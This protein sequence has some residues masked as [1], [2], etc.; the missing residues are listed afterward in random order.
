[1]IKEI[2]IGNDAYLIDQKVKQLTRDFDVI[3][4]S[5]FT[6]TEILALRQQSIFGKN[7]LVI[8]GKLDKASE[9]LLERFLLEDHELQ[10]ALIYVPGYEDRRKKIFKM[11]C[12]RRIEKLGI[13]ELKKLLTGILA[14]NNIPMNDEVL[15]Y[16]I[17]YSEYESEPSIS[18]YDLIG[19][20]KTSSGS[21]LTK[22]HIEKNLLRGE[23]DDAF[24][25]IHLIGNKEALIEYM[26]RLNSNPYMIIGA[27]LYAFRIMAKLQINND[28]GITSYQLNQYQPLKEKWTLEVIIEKMKVLNNLKEQHESKE[29]MKALIFSALVE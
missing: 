19:V 21:P 24:K 26:A 14:E 15:T 10:N 12:V 17:E 5:V 23:K 9:D 28:I 16:L 18:L 27:L 20:I 7:A 25:L 13:S 29:V 11:N 4:I 3:R 6:E 2:I 8:S 22:D 1:M